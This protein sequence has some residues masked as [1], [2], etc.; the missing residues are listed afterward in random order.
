MV[1]AEEERKKMCSQSGHERN[2]DKS[3][4]LSTSFVLRSP[5]ALCAPTSGCRALSMQ[6]NV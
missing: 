1:A 5:V 6:M 2:N 3:L 4:S